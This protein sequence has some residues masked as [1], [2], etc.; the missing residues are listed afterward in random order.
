MILVKQMHARGADA[1]EDAVEMIADEV[2]GRFYDNPNRTWR[3][4]GHRVGVWRMFDEYERAG[5]PTSCTLNSK[6]ALERR[7]IVEHIKSRNW[8]IVA[9]NYVQTEP[10][11]DHQ[12][13]IEA[14]R[15]VIRQTLQVY[16]DA[17]GKPAKGWLS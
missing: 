11:A 1:C 12:F 14:E 10:L 15:R 9:H 13:D 16:K 4:Y 8:E 17:V 7:D 3:E 6:L 5:V 2:P